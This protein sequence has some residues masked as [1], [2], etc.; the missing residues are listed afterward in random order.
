L[1]TGKFN[2]DADPAAR[3][4]AR[5]SNSPMGARTLT[6]EK[7]AIAEGLSRHAA[8]IGCSSAQLALAWLRQRSEVAV[9]PII[10]AR[11][12]AQ[13]EDNLAAAEVQLTPDQ[14][15]ALDDL[16]PPPARYPASLLSSEFFHRM[17]FGEPVAAGDRVGSE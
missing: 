8:E 12:L 17:M 5:L 3:A 4:D 11:H 14:L 16:A 13:L 1:L 15:A 7:R 9:V 2:A 10:G 6:D